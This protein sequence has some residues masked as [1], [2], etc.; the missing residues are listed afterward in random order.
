MLTQKRQI[1]TNHAEVVFILAG[2]ELSPH[3]GNLGTFECLCL[4]K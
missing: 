4:Q 1:L 3:I 2:L